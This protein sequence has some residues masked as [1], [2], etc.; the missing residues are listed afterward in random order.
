MT[1]TKRSQNSFAKR[2]VVA[3][4]FVPLLVAYLYY[5]P[6]LPY[7]LVLIGVAGMAAMWEFYSMYKVPAALCIPGIALGGI[8]MYLSC[9]YPS[10][11]LS[12]IFICLFLLLL[13]RLFSAVSPSGCMSDMGPLGIGLLYVGGFLSFQWFLRTGDMGMEYIFVLYTSVWL[14]DGG[15][16]YVGTYMGR[17]KL[18]PSISPHKTWEGA[19]GSVIGGAL[20]AVIVKTLLGMNGLSF[21]GSVVIGAV[22]GVTSLVGDL[23]ESMF[24]RD[25]GVKDS[26]MFI[27]GHG[28]ILDKLD[29]VL[30]SGPVLYFIVRYF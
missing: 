15:A 21:A 23:I 18:F 27:P 13:I 20:G 24:K 17:N 5:L 16:Y 2:H 25:A 29:G 11:I 28:G 8:L 26:S 6:P 4:I 12:G 22:M 19:F 10:F 3:I 9:R 14:A 1:D 30:V 7:F